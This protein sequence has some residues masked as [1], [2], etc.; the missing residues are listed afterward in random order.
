MRLARGERGIKVL[1]ESCRERDIA[2]A[3]YKDHECRR[4][5]DQLLANEP[6]ERVEASN[7]C[8][9]KRG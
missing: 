2:Y 6:L 8:V 9:S 4:I 5:A 7:S 3:E 1:D